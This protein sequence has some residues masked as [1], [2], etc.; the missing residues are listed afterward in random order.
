MI[1][2]EIKNELARA[3]MGTQLLRQTVADEKEKGI[4]TITANA[5]KNEVHAR[6]LYEKSGFQLIRETSIHAP[7]VGSLT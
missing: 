6:R 3:E 7:W 5:G 2:Q 4:K 1:I